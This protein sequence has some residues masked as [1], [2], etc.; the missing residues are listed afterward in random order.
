MIDLFPEGF[1]EVQRPLGV[2]LAAYTGPEG[3]TRLWRAFGEFSSSDDVEDD[4]ADRWRRFHRPV[5]IGALWIG[6]PWETPPGDATVVVIDPGRAF[7]TGA[8]ETTRLCLEL[9]GEVDR[10]SLLD[11]GCGSGVLAIAAAKLG[12]APVDALD[13]DDAAVAATRQNAAR[14]GVAVRVRVADALVDPLPEA[15]VSVANLSADAV[16]RLA[17]RLRSATVVTSG[18]LAGQAPSLPGFRIVKR[19]SAAGWVAD[20]AARER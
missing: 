17:P 6:P 7:G 4:W 14:N 11:V 12:F 8:H 1:E 5:R 19:V 10:S 15:A 3:A 20:L 18:Y 9:L 13:H 16:E 2:E